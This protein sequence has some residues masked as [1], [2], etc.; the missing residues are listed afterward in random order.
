MSCCLRVP[1][2]VHGGVWLLRVGES[3]PLENH[4]NW[5]YNTKVSA[6]Y[7]GKLTQSHLQVESILESIYTEQYDNC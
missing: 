6:V 1:Y 2:T 3:L 5:L 4:T 7:M